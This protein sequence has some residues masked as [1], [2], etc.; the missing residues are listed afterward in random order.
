MGADLSEIARWFQERPKWLQEATSRL[1]AKNQFS[2]DDLRELVEL[3][4]AEASGQ[5]LSYHEVSQESLHAPEVSRTLRL[6]AIEDMKGINA[7]CPTKPLEFGDN[8]VCIVYGRNGSGKSGYVRLLK[9]A[10][11]SRIC[12]RL[13]NNVFKPAVEKQYAKIVISEDGCK[14]EYIWTGGQLQGLDGVEIFDTACGVVYVNEENEVAYEPWL[15]RLFA[16]LTGLCVQVKKELEDRIRLLVPSKPFLPAE[17]KDTE[18]GKW[19]TGLSEDSSPDDVECHTSWND[20]YERTLNQIEKRLA[21]KDPATRAAAL[22]RRSKIIQELS[23][24]LGSQHSRLSEEKCLEY[25]NLKLQAEE[26]RHAAD[27]YAKSVFSGEPLSGIGSQAWFL[28]WEAARKF[29]AEFAY[30]GTPFPNLEV[31]SRCVLCQQELDS[32]SCN[33]LR[34]FEIFVEGELESQAKSVEVEVKN[35]EKAFPEIP[36]TETLN[37]K[38]DAAGVDDED[39]RQAVI[40]FSSSIM[41]RKE[42]CMRTRTIE[43]VSS[44]PSRNTLDRLD[45]LAA[46]VA[47]EAAQF[48]EDATKE[49]RPELEKRRKELGARKWLSQQL[50]AINDEIRRLASVKQVRTAIQLTNTTALSRKK[51][52]LSEALVTGAYVER[53]ENELAR[54][55][56]QHLLVEVEKTRTEEGHVYHRIS[57]KDCVHNINTS[58]VLSEGEFRIV[59]L[60]AFLA[61]SEGRDARTPFVFDDPISSLDHVYEEATAR[62]LVY[63]C[64]NRQV[65]VF[66]HRL[67]FLGLI[68][69]YSRKEHI[70]TSI[71]CLSEYRTGDITGLPINLSNTTK[72]VNTLKGERMKRARTAYDEDDEAYEREAKGLCRD[73]RILLERVVESDLLRDIVRRYNPEIQTKGKLEYLASIEVKDCRFIDELMTTYSRYEHSQPDETPVSLPTPDEIEQDLIKIANFIKEIASRGSQ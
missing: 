48:E 5:P 72:A 46:K 22:R 29:S 56:A 17:Y 41:K 7:L 60:A 43:C 58:E 40:R 36:D 64:K 52:A 71:V 12:G 67:S 2:N 18:S 68:E 51:S 27:R 21:E 62:R 50:T 16:S 66:T 3:C 49:N 42:S 38:M 34:E 19:F 4:L 44:L 10:C 57:L 11:G 13:L 69:K 28:L 35:A 73:I 30:P 26:K 31:G 63:L 55:K 59:S 45:D 32:E 23:K 47:E 33:R 24:D 54:L 61:D 8:Q 53:F 37:T 9:H 25:L 6:E 70:K 1:I 15:L 39:D 65:I 14:K 20:D